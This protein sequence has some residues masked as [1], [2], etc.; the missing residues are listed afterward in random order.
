MDSRTSSTA[1]SYGAAWLRDDRHSLF[2]AGMMWV[3]VVLMIVPEG[4]DY[5]SFAAAPVSGGAV[6][7]MLWLGLLALSAIILLWRAGL[8]WVLTRTLNPFLLVFVAL[9]VLSVAWS[10]DLSLSARRLVR[11]LTIVLACLAF[12]LMSWHARRFQSV[13]RP[14]LTVMLLGSLLFG[15]AF[16]TLAIH[17]ET[18]AEL[19]GAWRG[20]AN[21]K[22]GLG[23][24]S[25][26]ALIFW[27]HAWLARE[28]R[29]VPALA[30]GSIA[31]TCLVLSRSSTSLAATAFVMVLLLVLLRTPSNL[32]PYFA[33]LVSMLVAGLLV[34]AL[35]ILNL[36]PGLGTLMA[37]VVLLTDKAVTFTG[38]TEIWTIIS[39]HI[40]Y[41][42]F[43]GT[44]Y[45]AYWTAAPVPGTESYEFISR[46]RSF[47][48]GSAHN[49]YLEIVND[50][51]WV[52]LAC[53]IA[54]IATHVRQCL[55][56]LEIDRHQ[57]ALYLAL[58][59]QQ[60]ITNLSE[61][62][63][64]SVL[65]VDF[66]VMTLATTALARGLLEHQLR[67]IFGEP[68]P[69]IGGTVGGMALLLAQRSLP[70]IQSRQGLMP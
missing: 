14:I 62:H 63:W 50:L 42:P 10:I 36:I 39:D 33:F 44:G 11:M 32:R 19:I 2:L 25:C 53:L 48:P 13:V 64:F 61:T 6:S 55:R 21:H 9:A 34:Y 66:V 67:S 20:L 65:S 1:R 52:G 27:F 68:H 8:M 15:L 58:F 38:R 31:A 3:L 4:F 56:L 47:Y 22:N 59:F 18:S 7:R 45:G 49:G 57:S 54:Y 5:Q 24:L 41:R 30:G 51:G 26:L 37:P 12:V 60:A 40:R 17:Q 69:L 43:L 46:M 28:V 16:P 23:D 35:A 29:L 70:R